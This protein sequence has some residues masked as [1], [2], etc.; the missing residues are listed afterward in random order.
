MK[1]FFSMLKGS[2]Q[3]I[4]D[5]IRKRLQPVFVERRFH[6]GQ[7]LWHEGETNGCL[8]DLL[9][10]QVKI[11][12]PMPEGHQATVYIFGPGELFGFMPIFDDAPYP[13][14][15]QALGPVR[16]RL[17]SRERLTEA[18]R[19]DP[20]IAL[21]LLKQLSR[22]LRE[23]FSQIEVL[24]TRGVLM[25]AALALHSLPMT[26]GSILTIPVASHEY[27]A[28]YGL[29]PESFSRA[30]TQLVDAGILHRLGTPRK[31]QLLRPDALND[32]VRGKLEL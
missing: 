23:A 13:L 19:S 18:V 14:S 22:R 11:F 7:M 32:L 6:D 4:A 31:Y 17:V 12:R 8:T 29:S 27:A 10:G 3:D 24:S 1:P 5:A 15:A 28:L 30:I 21:L 20:E 26:D 2:D 16:V 9:E 25:R